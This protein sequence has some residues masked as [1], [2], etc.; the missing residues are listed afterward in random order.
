[1][2]IGWIGSVLLALC[3]VPEL[4]RTI[5]TKKCHIGFGMLLTW[6]FG[7]ILVLYYIMSSLWSAPMIF[8]YVLNIAIIS[9]MII[10]K[11]TFLETKGKLSLVVLK[12]DL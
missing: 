10:Y 11:L 7:E 12:E 9:V 3:A 4:I 2:S 6:Y 1:M 8:N 5:R